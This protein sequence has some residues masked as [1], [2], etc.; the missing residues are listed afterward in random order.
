MIDPAVVRPRR[1]QL[2]AE[3]GGRMAQI[4]SAALPAARMLGVL[5]GNDAVI[6][7]GFGPEVVNTTECGSS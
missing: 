3:T 4:V 7:I 5:V 1:L 2:V 6:G